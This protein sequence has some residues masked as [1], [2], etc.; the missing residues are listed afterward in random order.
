MLRPAFDDAFLAGATDEE[1]RIFGRHGEWLEGRYAE[2][3]VSFAGRCDGPFGLV[4]LEVASEEAA[5][6]LMREDPSVQGGV[7]SA[8]L[9]PF[10]TFLAREQRP[11]G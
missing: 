8:E 4:V 11:D 3:R 2:G 10:R 6:Q 9:Y 1:R 7:Q 5:R